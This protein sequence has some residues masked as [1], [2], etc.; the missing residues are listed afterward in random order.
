MIGPNSTYQ[1]RNRALL[2]GIAWAVEI[3]ATRLGRGRDNWIGFSFVESLCDSLQSASF[4]SSNQAATA[5]SGGWKL[6]AW[7]GFEELCDDR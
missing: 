5:T 6:E 2:V 4:A 1:E 3:I 7:A